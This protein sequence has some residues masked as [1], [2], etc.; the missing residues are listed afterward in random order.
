MD[1][2]TETD[3]MKMEARFKQFLRDMT[4]PESKP[5]KVRSTLRNAKFKMFED[6]SEAEQKEILAEKAKAGKD[7]TAMKA[8]QKKWGIDGRSLRFSK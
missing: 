3:A 7:K 6:Y 4:Q 5:T 1:I 2:A 8:V